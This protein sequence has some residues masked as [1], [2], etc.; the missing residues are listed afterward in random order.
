MIE[1]GNLREGGSGVVIFIIKG[2]IPLFIH[3]VRLRGILYLL[4]FFF[5]KSKRKCQRQR[6]YLTKEKFF[7]IFSTFY[8]EEGFD[9]Q[10][11]IQ[12]DKMYIFEEFFCSFSCRRDLHMWRI[13]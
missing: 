10:D 1:I 9:V 11:S 13:N 8:L 4:G 7:L 2:I 12:M 6:L 3:R 5:L